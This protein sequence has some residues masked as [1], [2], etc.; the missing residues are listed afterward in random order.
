MCTMTESA[1]DHP[2]IRN[3]RRLD[4]PSALV[5]VDLMTESTPPLR[6]MAEQCVPVLLHNRL[7]N[8]HTPKNT[9][10]HFRIPPR[11]LA[12]TRKGTA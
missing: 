2:T 12:S 1:V 4:L 10:D 5:L 9:P 6:L 8:P 11:T 3:P 7:G